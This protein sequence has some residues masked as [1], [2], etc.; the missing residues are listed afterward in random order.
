MKGLVEQT[1]DGIFLNVKHGGIVQE[2]KNPREGF[3]PIEVVNV[4]SGATVVK[5]IKRYKKVIAHIKKIEWYDREYED[6]RFMGWKLLLDDDDGTVCVL[7]LPFESRV[8]TRFMKLAENID[9]SQPV[10]FSAWKGPDDK[11]AF[12]VK[13][14]GENVPQK[15][16]RDSP[17]DCPPPVQ[18]FN[19]KWNFDAQKEFLHARMIHAVIPKVQELNSG[20]GHYEPSSPTTSPATE[21]ALGKI[22]T[23][24]KDYAADKKITLNDAIEQWFGTRSWADVEKMSP[25]VIAATEEKLADEVVPF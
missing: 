10:E 19:K 1:N 3:S 17:G 13:Q 4:R 22:Q 12:S 23:Y 7:D 14:N 18:G 5:Y 25:E 15:Y 21:E 20:N 6:T 9:Y 2:S 8:G 16:T 24:L 11:T